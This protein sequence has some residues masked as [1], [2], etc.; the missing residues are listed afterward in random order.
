MR[1]WQGTSGVQ[2]GALGLQPTLCKAGPPEGS[3]GRGREWTR[4]GHPLTTG[5]QDAA[6]DGGKYP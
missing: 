6:P 5:R 1:D 3:R 2:G 4:K